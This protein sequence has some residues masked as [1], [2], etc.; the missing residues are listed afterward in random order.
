VRLLLDAMCGGL[1]SYLRMC[2]HDAAYAIERGVEAD[3]RLAALADAED[4]RLVTRDAAL[5]AGRADAVLL[6]SRDVREQLRELRAAGVSLSLAEPPT[7]CGACN[8]RLTA[9]DGP[10]PEGVPDPD[11]E[12]A[13]RCVDCGQYFWTGSHWDRVRETLADL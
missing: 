11:E 12:A 8:G 3:D 2:G 5:A 9:V 4:R 13:F 6:E 1:R 7:R 10:T